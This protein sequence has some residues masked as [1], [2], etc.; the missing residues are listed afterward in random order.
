MPEEFSDSRR[1]F[2]GY[3]IGGIAGAITI[4]YAVPL[5]TYLIKPALQKEDEPWSLVSSIENIP[6]GQPTSLT[7]YS[8][9]KVGWEEKKAEHDVWVVKNPEGAVTVFSPVCPHLGCGYRWV[10]EI[11]HFECPCHASAYDI[12]GRVVA[13]PAPRPLDTLPSKVEEGR[14]YVKYE[15]Y[16]LGIPRKVEA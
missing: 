4:G 10:E 5:A 9:V 16:R 13:G 8:H 3:A 12:A 2:I 15:K 1:K 6:V 7:F 14:L 11:G